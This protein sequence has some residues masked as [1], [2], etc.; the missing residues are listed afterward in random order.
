MN[1]FK[2]GD[3]VEC[4]E[5]EKDYPK[6]KIGNIYTIKY[7]SNKGKGWLGFEES[8]DKNTGWPKSW[9]R[10]TTKTKTTKENKMNKNISEVFDKTKDALL[11]EKHL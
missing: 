10:L 9:F 4:I 3:K 11:V 5:T 1:E 7:E 6:I 2:V 8:G